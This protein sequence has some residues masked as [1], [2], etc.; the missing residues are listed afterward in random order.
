MHEYLFR[1]KIFF[2]DYVNSMYK[3]GD[4]LNGVKMHASAYEHKQIITNCNNNESKQ[5]IK[6][7]CF[8]LRTKIKKTHTHT[9]QITTTTKT[10]KPNRFIY[11]CKT[12]NELKLNVNKMS[13]EYLYFLSVFLNGKAKKKKKITNKQIY[14]RLYHTVL[15]S[16]FVCLLKYLNIYDF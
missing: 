7:E 11:I 16:L 4:R 15:Y 10:L 13:K 9:N 12:A 14:F 8:F 2:G 3:V 6:L 5:Y 1:C